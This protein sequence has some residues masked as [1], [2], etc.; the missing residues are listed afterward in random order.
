[1]GFRYRKSI[2]LG[3][4]FRINL[5]KSGVGYS[6]GTK[7][8][9]ITKTAKGKIRST[10]SI[11]GMGISYT[12]EYGGR[13]QN[14]VPDE[15]YNYYNTQEIQNADAKSITSDGLYEMLF[16]ANKALS[17]RKINYVIGIVCLA[18]GIVFPFA[19]IGVVICICFLFYLKKRA[20]INLKYYF[21][22]EQEKEVNER[23]R[24]L[25][26]ISESNKL[27]WISQTSCVINKKYSAG[28]ANSVKRQ[29]CVASTKV[30]FPFTCNSTA[31]AF[32]SGK[33]TLLFLP[34]KL[35]VMQ[36]IK[37]GAVS[38]C[39]VTTSVRGTRFVEEELVPK[40]AKIVDYTWQ[41]VNKS[42]APDKRFQNN[43]KIPVCLYGEMEVR[44]GNG[45]NTVIMFSNVD[46]Q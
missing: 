14:S 18:I 25:I 45:I 24:P 29:R 38:Y 37:V 46:I 13:K 17:L 15:N 34:D 5:S 3:G 4:G 10:T 40:D 41:Y 9:R 31:V 33:E 1:M 26:K 12:K 43:K 21:Y 23:M 7:G 16:A 42:G 6:W 44:S 11:P 39:D 36:G 35:F 30:P 8:Y 22:D 32:K 27:W 28:A 2:N 19:L 20:I